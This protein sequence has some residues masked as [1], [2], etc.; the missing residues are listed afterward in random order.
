MRDKKQ[1]TESHHPI[2]QQDEQIL[3]ETNDQVQQQQ[4]PDKRKAVTLD[5]K[6]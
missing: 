6:L 1:I 4:D 3:G 5:H 2:T